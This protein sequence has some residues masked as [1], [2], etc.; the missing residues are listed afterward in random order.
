MS[1]FYVIERST[2]EDIANAIREK[3]G[4][5]D[6]ILVSNLADEITSIV[7]GGG[8]VIKAGTYKLVEYHYGYENPSYFDWGIQEFH[9]KYTSDYG[10][11]LPVTRVENDGEFYVSLGNNGTYVAYITPSWEDNRKFIVEEDQ[12]VSKNFKYWFDIC[13]FRSSDF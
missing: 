13:F 6:N 11:K 10:E 2:L 8:N 9:G 7:T 4:T 3:K 1:E 5:T 12:T